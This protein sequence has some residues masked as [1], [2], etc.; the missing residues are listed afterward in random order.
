M[1]GVKKA[2][3]KA[4]CA[5]WSVLEF[6]CLAQHLRS[7]SSASGHLVTALR[8]HGSS[9]QGLAALPSKRMLNPGTLLSPPPS[10]VSSCPNLATPDSEHFLPPHHPTAHD[11]PQL[12]LSIAL[13]ECKSLFIIPP[14]SDLTLLQSNLYPAV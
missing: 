7:I 12:I 9:A 14:A 6:S 4:G 5:A 13:D 2:L 8:N 10:T 1:K 11:Q 3:G